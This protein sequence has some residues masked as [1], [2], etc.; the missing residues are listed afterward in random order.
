MIHVS[1]AYAD[2]EHN[3]SFQV[4]PLVLI[5]VPWESIISGCSFSKNHFRLLCSGTRLALQWSDRP[6]VLELDCLVRVDVIKG[7]V[8]TNLL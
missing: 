3:P 4:T 7:K 1:F 2:Y 6:V 8:G 5:H